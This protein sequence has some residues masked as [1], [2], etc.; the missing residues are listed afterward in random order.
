MPEIVVVGV[1]PGPVE[2]LT[3]E[4]REALLGAGQ[5]YFRFSA[6]P[7]FE[8]LKSKGVECISFDHIYSQPGI[9]YDRIYRLINKALIKEAR[10]RGRVTYALPGNPYVFEK[11]PRWLK[12]ECRSEGVK[13]MVIPGMSFLEYI[14]KELELDPEEGLEILN[15]ARLVEKEEAPV[16][17]GNPLL[18]GQ[19][20]TPMSNKPANPE[21]NLKALT[22]LLLQKFPAQHRITLIW[23]E[24]MPEYKTRLRTFP[25]EELPDQKEF[26]PHLA[27]LYVPK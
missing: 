14:Y 21:T 18:I 23:C 22:E 11:T 4:A 6:H 17:S 8:W 13:V 16:L 9:T 20:G 24:G 19:V 26:V 15:A 5:V 25:L 10:R 7:V 3:G 1:G 2:Q 12:G 27:T